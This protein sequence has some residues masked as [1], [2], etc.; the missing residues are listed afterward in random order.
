MRRTFAALLLVV[1]ACTSSTSPN[2][3]TVVSQDRYLEG[4]ILAIGQATN[5][6]AR[7][8]GIAAGIAAQR[9]DVIGLQEVS[10]WRTGAPVVCAPDGS[11][12]QYVNDPAAAGLRPPGRGGRDPGAMAARGPA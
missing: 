12:L 1:S 3:I 8:E 9:P 2:Q 5:F 7:A 4:D 10:I 6:P 11:G